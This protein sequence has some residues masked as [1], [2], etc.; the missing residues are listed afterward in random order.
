MLKITYSKS[1]GGWY[2]EVTEFRRDFL[3]ST[4]YRGTANAMTK[5]E[6]KRKAIAN[7]SPAIV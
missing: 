1:D 6:A 7:L 2:C 3:G 4:F 5:G